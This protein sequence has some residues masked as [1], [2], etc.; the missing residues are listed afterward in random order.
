MFNAMHRNPTVTK[1]SLVFFGW[2]ALATFVW[3]WV[4]GVIFR[5]LAP[6]RPRCE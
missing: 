4:P 6:P 3:Q 2:V 1:K 5:T